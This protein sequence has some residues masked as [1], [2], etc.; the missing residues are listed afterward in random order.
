MSLD[1]TLQNTTLQ[2]QIPSKYLCHLKDKEKKKVLYFIAQI[3][4]KAL[5]TPNFKPKQD[6]CLH[7]TRL[8]QLQMMLKLDRVWILSPYSQFPFRLRTVSLLTASLKGTALLPAAKKGILTLINHRHTCQNRY[9]N[10][11]N[12]FP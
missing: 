2:V 6:S 10:R 3:V 7:M 11:R 8:N 4:P 5:V 12:E 1:Y 9:P